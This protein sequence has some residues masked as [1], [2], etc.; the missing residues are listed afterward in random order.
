[1]YFIASSPAPTHWFI[2]IIC[3]LHKG[4]LPQRSNLISSQHIPPVAFDGALNVQCNYLAPPKT[5]S[6]LWSKQNQFS[7]PQRPSV[8]D[9]GSRLLKSIT[10]M[11]NLLLC[12]QLNCPLPRQAQSFIVCV[13]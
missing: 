9:N 11:I 7:T 13:V 1:M 3:R 8:G 4:I 5:L 12:D 10:S 6:S 2:H